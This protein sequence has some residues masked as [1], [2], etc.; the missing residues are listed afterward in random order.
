MLADDPSPEVRAKVAMN[1]VTPKADIVRLATDPEESVRLKVWHGLR[2]R[3]FTPQEAEEMTGITHMDRVRAT[4]EANGGTWGEHPSHNVDDKGD[5]AGDGSGDTA[6]DESS[7]TA[8]DGSG[9]ASGNGTSEA[10]SE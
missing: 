8:G 9:D 1:R 6:S 7:D 3:G 2:V 5:E 4:Y 10:T